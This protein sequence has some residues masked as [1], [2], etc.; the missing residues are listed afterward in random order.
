MAARNMR[1]AMCVAL[2][3]AFTSTPAVAEDEVEDASTGIEQRVLVTGSRIKRIDIETVPVT[4]ISRDDIRAAGLQNVGDVLR[5]LNQADALGLTNLTNNTN[6]NDGTQ[7]I[8]L[9]GLGSARTLVLV[10]GRR[11]MVGSTLVGSRVDLTQIPVALIDRV[12]ILGDGASAIY[13]SDAVAGVVN[14]ITR[15]EYDGMEVDLS[16]GANFEGDGEHL[17]YGVT[18]GTVGSR[19][20]TL[21]SISRTEQREIWAGDRERTRLAIPFFPTS[22][23]VA[24]EYG[25]FAPIPCALVPHIEAPQCPGGTVP[26]G[27]RPDRVIPGLAPDERTVE[28]FELLGRHHFYNFAPAN[29]LLTPSD[30]LTAFAGARHA[31]SDD[32]TAFAQFTFNQ[33]KSE[34]QIAAVPIGLSPIAAP[35]WAFPVS[36]DNLYNPFGIDIPIA[37]FRM[38][39]LGGGRRMLQD[40]DTYFVTVGLEGQ[41]PL[42]P[43]LLGWDIAFSRGENSRDEIGYNFVNLLHLRHGVGPSFIDPATGAPTC[44]TPDAPMPMHGSV[45]CVPINLFNGVAGWTPAMVDYVGY[46]LVESMHVGTRNRAANVTTD[47]AM[48][49][50][51]PLAVAA[52]VELRTQTQRDTPDSLIAQGLSSTNLREPS[53][54]SQGIEE[55]YVELAV[56]LMRERRAVRMLEATLAGR[57][58][59]YMNEGLVGTEPVRR[60]FAKTALKYSLHYRPTDAWMLRASHGDV[61]RAPGVM[62][63]FAG[64]GESFGGP[65]DLCAT[66][67]LNP[68]IGYPTLTPGQ[69]ANCHAQ[70]V[71]VGG[72]LPGAERFMFG[73]NPFLDPEQ[74]TTSNVGILYSPAWLPALDVSV[75]RWQVKLDDALGFRGP[76]LIMQGCILEGDPIDCELIERDP[77]TGQ[78]QLTRSGSFNIFR[79]RV[80]GYDLNANYRVGRIRFRIG[81]TYVQRAEQRLTEASDADN[82]VGRA[83]GPFGPV[84]RWRTNITTSWDHGPYGLTWRVRTFSPLVEPCTAFVHLFDLGLTTRQICSHPD[85][86]PDPAALASATNRVGSVVYHDL[87]GR[88]TAPWGGAL[89]VG[90]RNVLRKEPP[91]MVTP[92][93]NGF[94]QAYDIPG[95]FWFASYR[96]PL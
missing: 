3:L 65:F 75:D 32:I 36:A 13:G 86:S 26:V 9:R 72:T 11:W 76:A 22:G 1:G 54:G 87:T 78:L 49:P 29:Y 16:V 2:C 38:T 84:W 51:G 80:A 83:I 28:D 90:V 62:E 60:D 21:F 91:L 27:L 42:G 88:W 95:G 7:T 96:Q 59:E 17:A 74:G 53:R 61:F 44:G 43:R 10:N 94:G 15:Q 23:S 58:S 85:R 66:H 6:A 81:A 41:V 31:V 55:Y 35:Q 56:P 12:E 73:G 30:R 92:F 33:R 5:N 25:L 34:T 63:L 45:N 40:Y 24:G 37:A 93:A 47:L 46:T 71:P 68:N 70:G 8:S 20:S 4:V 50:A 14:L 82:V 57:R 67:P 52:G 64:G 19:S 79:A 69:Q 39:P 77:V 18:W 89:H 48:L